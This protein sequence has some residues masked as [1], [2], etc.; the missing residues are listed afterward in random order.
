MAVVLSAG[1][2]NALNS[3]SQTSAQASAT[4]F[5]LATGKKV[6]SA[7]DNPSNFFISAGL[8]NRASD[9]SR[10][11]D[12]IGQA[13]K[14]LEAADKGITAITK[15][16]ESAQATAR[17]ALQSTSTTPKVR[18]TDTYTATT[19]IT[20]ALGT[21]FAAADTI[22]VNG[23]TVLTVAANDTVQ[24]LIDGINN[25]TTLNPAGSPPKI[26]ASLDGNGKL[27]IESLDG[28]ALTVAS[29]NAAAATS[30]FGATTDL[31][32]D[33]A[34]NETR[35]TLSAQLDSLREQIDQLAKDASYNGINL[36]NGGSLKV[37]F[38][39]DGSSSLT[40]KGVSFDSAGLKIDEAGNDLQ[41]DTDI[42]NAL[43]DLK[44]AADVLRAQ[45][46]TFGSNLGVVNNR[47]EFTKGLI[48][49]LTTGSDAL[50]VADVNEEGAN[51]LA[52]NT[53]SQLSQTAL[54]LASQADQA[55]LRLF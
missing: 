55:V 10:L 53:R 39:E 38:N 13:V 5:R 24:D 44:K 25:N 49:T 50:V 33:A 4:Q 37:L 41:S 22:T 34:T 2:R 29:S 14:V 17:Q 9:L 36:L 54:S 28:A 40:V 21:D 7:L 43:D 47:Q 20:A 52:L 45:A 15:L 8:A 18:S 42:N 46:S 26:K 19:D 35:K 27:L 32:P 48:T 23:T 12:D 30:L 6:N 51:L 16:V 11:Q 1:V 3:L 31:T